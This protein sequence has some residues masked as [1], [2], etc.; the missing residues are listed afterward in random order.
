MSKNLNCDFKLPQCCNTIYFIRL[1]GGLTTLRTAPDQSLL[2]NSSDD[3]G[4]DG[5][6]GDGEDDG[7][8]G[9]DGD[10]EDDGDE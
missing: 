2:I 4:S 9:D 5:D 1:F 3:D 6:D 10:D 7:D 8:D